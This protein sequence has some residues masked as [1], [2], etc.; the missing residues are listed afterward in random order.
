M[1]KINYKGYEIV[2][3]HNKKIVA[4]I[5]NN[6]HT[7]Q[8]R[9]FMNSNMKYE[10]AIRFVFTNYDKMISFIDANPR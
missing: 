6:L 3:T 7:M 8:D 9:G 1:E 4:Q 5:K 2:A 10:P